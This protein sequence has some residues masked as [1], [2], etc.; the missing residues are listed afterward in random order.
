[1]AA[2][3]AGADARTEWATADRTET[4]Q[5]SWPTA[6]SPREAEP[7]A[8]P[9]PAPAKD[10]QDSQRTVV[11]PAP[12]SSGAPGAVGPATSPPTAGKPSPATAAKADLASA[13]TVI[14]SP[15]GSAGHRA[16]PAA[17]TTPADT[18]APEAADAPAKESAVT[19]VAASA[20]HGVT[21]PAGPSE[22]AGA[23][24]SGTQA[25]QRAAAASAGGS[26]AAA[27]EVTIVPGIARYHLAD[28]ILIRFLGAED[29][30]S[31]SR[32]A[33]EEAGCV[34]CRA[35]RPEKALASS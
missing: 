1:V 9:E 19:K 13:K 4:A 23:G 14:A 34:P 24:D 6:V 8:R 31:M 15:A 25:T 29:L 17:R 18:G 35:C 32:Q 30:E 2:G 27:Q 33:A 12:A 10:R 20:A 22:Q 5:P 21:A 26:G 16:G 28:C 11:T 7:A 3:W